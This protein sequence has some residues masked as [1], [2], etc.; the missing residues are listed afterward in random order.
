MAMDGLCRARARV[1]VETKA[2][3]RLKYRRMDD[4]TE[5]DTQQVVLFGGPEPVVL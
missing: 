5:D 2:D 3:W 1:G 4:A